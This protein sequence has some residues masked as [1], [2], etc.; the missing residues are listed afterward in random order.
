[1]Q[2]SLI[3][4]AFIHTSILCMYIILEGKI[5]ENTK[6]KSDFTFFPPK[7]GYR[8][9]LQCRNQLL[10]NIPMPFN[11]SRSSNAHTYISLK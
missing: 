7:N 2:Q 4:L 10:K 8:R 1:M 5:K 9:Q 6:Y 11:I 3:F